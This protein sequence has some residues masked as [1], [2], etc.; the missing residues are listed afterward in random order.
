MT[1]TSSL[2]FKEISILGSGSFGKVYKVL[3]KSDNKHYAMKKVNLGM[4]GAKERQNA[5]NEIRILASIQD[6]NVISY[7]D[8]FFDESSQCICIVMEYAAKG[9]LATY[10]TRLKRRN[11]YISEAKF[12]IFA[13]QIIR[14]LKALHEQKIF[15]RDLKLANIMVDSEGNL[16]VGDLN[17]A[18]VAKYGMALTQ[19]GTPY[20]ASP[21]IWQNKAY[22]EKSD[23]YSLGC[24][25]YEML[26]NRPPFEA[27]DMKSLFNKVIRGNFKAIGGTY[28][29]ETKSLVYSCLKMKPNTRPSCEDLLSLGIFNNI[30]SFTM[31]QQEFSSFRDLPP[32]PK[33]DSTSSTKLLSTIRLPRNYRALKSI[34]PKSQYGEGTKKRSVTFDYSRKALELSYHSKENNPSM[35]NI[36]PSNSGNGREARQKSKDY[37][38]PVYQQVKPTR[39]ERRSSR[40]RNNIF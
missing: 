34:L 31:K 37:L 4:L 28:S 39:Y 22:D 18:K 11:E 17:V 12:L 2:D 29:A 15:H 20:Y 19:T 33:K 30:D 7:K 32:L 36:L 10:F 38:P 16:K 21:E 40:V 9:D 25:F 27:I 1:E 5:L 14:G 13:F 8:A 26:S 35:A 23:I 6:A 24:I 3:R